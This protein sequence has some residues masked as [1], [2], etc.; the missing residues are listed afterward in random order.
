[1]GVRGTEFS[2][3]L[4]GDEICAEDEELAVE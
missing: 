3:M 1:M 4:C 2:I